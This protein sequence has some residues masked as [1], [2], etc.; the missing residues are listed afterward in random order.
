MGSQYYNRYYG[1]LV[2][3][4]YKTLPFIQLAVKSTDYYDTYV[5]N[6]TRFDSLSEKYYDVPYYTWLILQANP[7]FGGLEFTVTN[8]YQIRIPYPLESTLRE[9]NDKLK[10]HIKLYG[11]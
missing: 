3:G 8:G 11:L 5:Q 1:F 2:N 10:E 4:E 6:R 7:V 9:Y